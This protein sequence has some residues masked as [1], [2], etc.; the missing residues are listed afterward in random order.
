MVEDTGRD[1]LDSAARARARAACARKPKG[2]HV[3]EFEESFRVRVTAQG[4][5]FLPSLVEGDLPEAWV[6]A[7]RAELTDLVPP[8]ASTAA[9][10]IPITFRLTW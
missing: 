1:A 9:I 5:A 10:R 2:W 4:D 3:V 7:V 8:L 6:S